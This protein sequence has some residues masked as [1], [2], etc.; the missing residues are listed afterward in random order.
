MN[1]DTNVIEWPYISV[2]IYNE[3]EK[4]CLGCKA[5][6]TTERR[7]AYSIIIDFLE[8]FTLRKRN[9][10]YVVVDGSTIFQNSVI[11]IYN[12]LDATC[13]LD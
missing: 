1:R 6:I 11:E 3:L 13:V 10:D 4:D 2:T 12:L 8:N 7:E 9:D 5:I